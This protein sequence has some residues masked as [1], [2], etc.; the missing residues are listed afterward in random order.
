[1]AVIAASAVILAFAGVAGLV[2]ASRRLA[3]G[4]LIGA[5]ARAGTGAGLLALAA[6]LAG[7][8]LNLATY[9]R[10][11]HEQEVGTLSVQALG[12]GEYLVG[13]A[14]DG[15]SR[16][17]TFR[18][19]GDEWRL[20]ARV[21]KWHGWANLLGMD[22]HFRLERLSGRYR[23]AERERTAPRTVHALADPAGLDLWRL[24]RERPGWIPGLDARYGSAVFLPLA[25]G[26][27]YRVAM[28]QSGLVAR[29]ANDAARRTV[30]A[31]AP[32]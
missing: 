12:A 3:A 31:W 14:L 26:V 28:T 32:G 24:A 30:S 22:A 27:S 7:I 11:T 2:S 4:R 17:R 20:E 10:L 6:L 25:D 15:E 5:G 1:M 8:G 16:S 29:P 9:E 13:L 19:R 23:S 21:L 18:L